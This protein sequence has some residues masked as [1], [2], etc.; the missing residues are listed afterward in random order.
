MKVEAKWS[1]SYPILCRGEWTLFIDGKDISDK[2][3]KGLRI[4]PMY[5][6]GMYSRWRFVNGWE[7]EWNNYID[8]LECEDWIEENKEWLDEITTDKC[9]QEDIY[10]AF[11]VNDWRHGSC[12]G[13]I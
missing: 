9:E 5:T 7:A 10:Y 12:G 1:G 11:Q 2:I 4:N 6:Y 13:C 8:G 3:P